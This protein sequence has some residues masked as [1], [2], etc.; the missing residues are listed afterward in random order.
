MK[1]LNEHY[2]SVE[3]LTERDRRH[4]FKYSYFFDPNFPNDF[5]K[6]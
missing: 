3:G 4:S 1:K 6:K 5:G 2:T